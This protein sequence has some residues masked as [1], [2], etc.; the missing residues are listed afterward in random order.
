[1]DEQQ[2]NSTLAT[3]AV[4]LPTISVMILVGVSDAIGRPLTLLWVDHDLGELDRYRG[5]ANA[6]QGLALI[7][8]FAG[9][10]WAAALRILRKTAEAKRLAV[11]L[12]W[13]CLLAWPAGY[14]VMLLDALKAMAEK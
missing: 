7:I 1:M 3:L 13:G 9:W 10:A 4:V 11:C 14:L 2:R 6:L 12:F 8:P 5:L